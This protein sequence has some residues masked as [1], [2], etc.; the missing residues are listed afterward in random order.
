MDKYVID[1]GLLWMDGVTMDLLRPPEFTPDRLVL[2]LYSDDFLDNILLVDHKFGS[3]FNGDKLYFA[4]SF[5]F[6]YLHLH[7]VN[8]QVHVIYCAQ[9]M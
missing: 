3:T 6:L 1:A 8:A 5:F 9:Y 7:A 4:M 2:E